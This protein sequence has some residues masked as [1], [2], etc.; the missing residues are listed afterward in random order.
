VSPRLR[1]PYKNFDKV[2][3]PALP[4][5]WTATSTLGSPDTWKTAI[6]SEQG[7]IANPNPSLP[8]IV[9]TF[10]D[11]ASDSRLESPVFQIPNS[12]SA[13]LKFKHGYQFVLTPRF[14]TPSAAVN[15][16]VLEISINGGGF[17][18]IL[19]AGGS[20]TKG[21]Y[22]GPILPSADNPLSGRQG[23]YGSTYLSFSG[24]YSY[25][26]TAVSLPASALGQAVKFRWR[27]GTSEQG[28]WRLDDVSLDAASVPAA[29]GTVEKVSGD[30]QSARVQT[31]YARPLQVRVVNA[32]GQPVPGVSV[33]FTSS[34]GP[35][36]LA[37]QNSGQL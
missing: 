37:F 30:N 29:P 31:T 9:R 33:N 5:G 23:W 12:T 21:G 35:F 19:A 22:E 20:F 6:T 1:L 34:G 15:G 11:G 18:D 3:V 28:Q 16:G 24:T 8:N 36:N 13:E 32:S 27:M 2:G 10:A 14:G 25:V 7:A 4:S 17:Q 26:E